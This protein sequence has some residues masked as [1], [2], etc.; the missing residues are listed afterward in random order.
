VTAFLA[1]AIAYPERICLYKKNLKLAQQAL[2]REQQGPGQHHLGLP[3][4]G[5]SR[6]IGGVLPED[7]YVDMLGR[8]AYG[9]GLNFSEYDWAVEK[10]RNAGKV[11]WWSELG[12]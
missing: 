2:L 10:K 11:I 12:I 5:Q 1:R 7:A 9:T 6:R 3:Y 8:S 4:H